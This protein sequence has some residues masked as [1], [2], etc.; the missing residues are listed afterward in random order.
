MS[1]V[2]VPGDTNVNPIIIF[3]LGSHSDDLKV[4]SLS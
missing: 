4:P 1:A 2:S 3:K